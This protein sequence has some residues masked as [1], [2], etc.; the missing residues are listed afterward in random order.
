MLLDHWPTNITAKFAFAWVGDAP[1]GVSLNCQLQLRSFDARRTL[2]SFTSM[3]LGKM[4]RCFLAAAWIEHQDVKGGH[5]AVLEEQV[6]SFLDA[7]ST[8][9]LFPARLEHY[10]V[11]GIVAYS[12]APCFATWGLQT[13]DLRDVAVEIVC[14]SA[15]YALRKEQIFCDAFLPFGLPNNL[16]WVY[17]GYTCNKKAI[18]ICMLKLASNIVQHYKMKG[19]QYSLHIPTCMPKNNSNLHLFRNNKPAKFIPAGHSQVEEN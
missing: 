9:E 18:E 13:D 11:I 16:A 6:V 8:D 12:N 2:D 10:L 5:S 7:V 17:N 19:Q 4:G 14:E 3:V 15:R 1:A